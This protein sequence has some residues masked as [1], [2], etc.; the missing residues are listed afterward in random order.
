MNKIFSTVILISTLTLILGCGAS[1]TPNVE[2]ETN[3]GPKPT[4]LVNHPV[5]QSY[6][7]GVGS[8]AKNKFGSE[9]QKSAQDL[10]LADMASQITVRITSDIVTTL[11]E[12]GEI[13]ED[14]YLAT[15]RSEAIADLE[16]HELV[17]TWQDAGYHYAYYRLSKA[18]YAA[19]QAR[20]RQVATSLSLDFLEKAKDA[21][22][23]NN[24]AESFNASIQAFIPLLPYLNEAL[25]A[26]ID[27]QS[28]IL[29]NEVNSHLQ[30]LLSDVTLTPNQKN[31]SGKLGQ[32]IKQKLTVTARSGDKQVMRGLPLAVSFVKGSGEF[33]E[34][35]NTSSKGFAEL[36]ISSITAPLKLQV[37]EISVDISGLLSG[38][39]SPILLAIVNSIPL[40]S[41]RIIIDV[42]NPSI[43]LESS[44]MFNGQALKQLQIEP[45]L[46]NHFIKEGFHFVDN[47][48]QADWQMTL[49]AT[50]TQGVE[51]SG[52]YTTF[53]DVSLNV[54]DRNTGDE[55]YKN[56]LSRVKGIDLSYENAA[57]KAFNNATDKLITTVLPQILESIK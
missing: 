32:P 21:N 52:M 23:L 20:K 1:T 16:G 10:A 35:I 47:V 33:A 14:E 39:H 4:W 54:I 44:E 51:Y 34:S 2:P 13:T 41:T 40:A 6:Y 25:K 38:D 3:Y 22:E 11:I 26:N 5:D 50:A 7:V 57:N 43:Y 55:I 49:N 17:D 18:K 29:S 56:A 31:I 42:S 19:I 28:V 24:F 15:A 27:G 8:A 36:Q 46:K 48:K 12:K 9:A 45:R 30:K 37:I 53:A